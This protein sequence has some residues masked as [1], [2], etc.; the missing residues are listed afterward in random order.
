[1][2]YELTLVDDKVKQLVESVGSD[3]KVPQS[4]LPVVP[5][6]KNDTSMKW[7]LLPTNAKQDKSVPHCDAH[8]PSERFG[9]LETNLTGL[10]QKEPTRKQRNELRN[11]AWA[12][13]GDILRKMDTD[14]KFMNRIRNE[15]SLIHELDDLVAD[16]YKRNPAILQF[17][18]DV[19]DFLQVIVNAA[20]KDADVKVD[21]AINDYMLKHLYICFYVGAQTF[22]AEHEAMMK[23]QRGT[24]K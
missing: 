6:S 11:V 24:A 22:L 5:L 19:V 13:G 10:R 1:M 4:S 17:F 15:I 18:H 16:H 7:A 21:K 2:G 12:I 9:Q 8:S 14:E 23:T 3:T 20:A